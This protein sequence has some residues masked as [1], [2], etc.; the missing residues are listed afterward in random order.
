M[1]NKE[2]LMNTLDNA[3][4]N[5]TDIYYRLYEDYFEKGDEPEEALRVIIE[6]SNEIGDA[7]DNNPQ[8]ITRPE[9][10]R[11]FNLYEGILHGIVDRI[12]EMNLTQEEFYKKLY[13]VVFDSENEL[14]PQSKEEKVIALKI[15]SE[16]VLAI[17]Y[18]PIVEIN[19]ISREEFE[20]GLEKIQ[21]SLREAYYMLNRQ[22]STTPE[23]GAQ[24]VRIADSIPDKRQQIIFW[25]VIINNLRA[26][27][28]KE[29]T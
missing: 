28:E 7:E 25:T 26:S 27:N 3:S 5:Q 16:R 1:M 19:Q 2:S 24:I 17:P 9:E 15:L 6:Y 14:L 20:E 10:N 18:Y 22:F 4:A 11:I 21:P 29:S 13:A 23:E 12:T 8:K